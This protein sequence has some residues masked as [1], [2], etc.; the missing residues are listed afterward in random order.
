MKCP[1]P[2]RLSVVGV[3]GPGN[4]EPPHLAGS[5]SNLKQLGI[6]QEAPGGVVIDVAIA[7]KD[8]YGV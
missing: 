6:S 3:D 7:S 4:D 5:C 2:L 1:D 8:L